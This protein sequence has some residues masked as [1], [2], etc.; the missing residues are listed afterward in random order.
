MERD[1]TPPNDGASELEAALVF[2]DRARVSV[3]LSSRVFEGGGVEFTATGTLRNV[4]LFGH[5]STGEAATI[6]L[7]R[8]VRA[9]RQEH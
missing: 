3:S 4:Q 9:R 2:L 1:V 6:E 7:A 8:L 5:G